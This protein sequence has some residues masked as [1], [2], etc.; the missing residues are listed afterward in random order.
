MVNEEKKLLKE[1]GVEIV[2]NSDQS[3]FNLEIHSSR[4]LTIGGIK[5]VETVVQALSL[6]L[7][8]TRYSRLYQQLTFSVIY[9]L[10]KY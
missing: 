10:K 8:V 5:K 9:L 4:T 7:I 6:L 1:Y 2:C 3:G